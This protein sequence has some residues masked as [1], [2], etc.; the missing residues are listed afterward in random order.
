MDGAVKEEEEDESD[1]DDFLVAEAA[2][3]DGERPPERRRGRGREE[4]ERTKARERRRRAVTGRIL[5][6]LRRHGG[7]GLR[8]RADVNEV[9]AALARHAGWVVLPDGTTFP[10]SSSNPHPQASSSL[11]S[12]HFFLLLLS[13]IRTSVTHASSATELSFH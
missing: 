11:H 1:S 9:V 7:F 13:C 4:K 10:T 5:A 6:G 2:A 12:I 8:P 3:G